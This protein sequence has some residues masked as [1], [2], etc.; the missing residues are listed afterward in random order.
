MSTD[1]ECGRVTDGFLF[2]D[3]VAVASAKVIETP[4]VHPVDVKNVLKPQESLSVGNIC[5]IRR[6]GSVCLRRD[7]CICFNKSLDFARF[8]MVK[9]LAISTNQPSQ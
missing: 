2:R 3:T 7:S 6:H 1:G 5:L 4:V 9:R 8:L